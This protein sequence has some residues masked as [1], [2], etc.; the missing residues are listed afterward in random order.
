MTVYSNINKVFVTTILIVRLITTGIR[1]KAIIFEPNCSYKYFIRTDI[2]NRI[3]AINKRSKNDL[4]IP[5]SLSFFVS[6]IFS[7]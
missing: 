7:I 4:N 6:F 5:P 1:H 3:K 2:E